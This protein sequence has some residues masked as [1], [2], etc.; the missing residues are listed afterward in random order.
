[1]D[2]A[3]KSDLLVVNHRLRIPRSEFEFTFARSSGP[4]GQNVNKVNSKAIL[5]W[6]L[7]ASPSV[8][9]EVRVRL[10]TQQRRRMTREG[11]LLVVSQRY[12]DQARNIDDCLEKLREMLAEAA[13][14]PVVRRVTKPT[15]GMI[16]RRLKQKKQ[17]SSK[18]RDRRTGNTAHDE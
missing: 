4:G 7:L 1:M 18:K 9:E 13:I 2:D 10:T 3:S 5:R 6:P 12:R 11:D 17:L 16:E 8:P 14:R 15:R